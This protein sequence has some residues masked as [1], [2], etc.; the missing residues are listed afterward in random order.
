MS[1][2]KTRSPF[3][4]RTV[5]TSLLAS[6]L[7]MIIA[8][9]ALQA[10]TE[11]ESIYESF[12]RVSS[13]RSRGQYEQAIEILKGIIAEQAKSDE[14]LRQAYNQLVFTFLSKQDLEAATVSAREALSRYPEIKADLGNI[15]EEV[16]ELYSNLRA[17]MY[18]ALNV[19]TKPDSCRVILNG[20]LL[21][22]LSPINIPYVKVGEYT[23]NVN[24]SGYKDESTTVRI[25]PAKP[26]S[27]PVSLQ[28]DRNKKWWLLRAGPVVVLAGVLAALGL[29]GEEP[30]TTPAPAPLPPPPEPPV[31]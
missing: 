20:D 16:N 4:L 14:I 10:Q 3:W 12:D 5:G 17:Q 11:N 2:C 29:Q 26:T 22:G 23:L 25:E 18:G 15:P 27:V 19:V 9:T 28:R 31:Q 1:I 24:K 21:K 13:L 8:P 7:F 30:S 6:F